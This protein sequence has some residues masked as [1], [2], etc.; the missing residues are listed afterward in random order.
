MVFRNRLL[1]YS[2]D[3]IWSSNKSKMAAN[4]MISN[5]DE[6]LWGGFAMTIGRMKENALD[7]LQIIHRQILLCL[8]RLFLFHGKDSC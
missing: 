3:A 4:V 7:L 1:R 8:P 5:V 2:G 6:G